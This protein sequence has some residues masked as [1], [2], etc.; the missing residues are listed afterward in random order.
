MASI[1]RI[2]KKNGEVVYRITVC[3]GYDN[4]GK[5]MVKHDTFRVNQ[6]ATPKQ[7]EKEAQKYALDFEDKMKNGY[8]FD[9]EKMTFEEFAEQ[10]VVNIKEELEYGTYECYIFILNNRL[11]PHFKK[12]KLA[13]IKPPIIEDFY[14]KLSHELSDSTLKKHANVLSGIFSTAVRWGIL[15]NNPCRYAKL[16]KRKESGSS[17]KFFTPEQATMFLRSLD[18]VYETEYKGHKRIDD[19]GKPYY[20]TNYVEKHKVNTQ[21]KV[22]YSL[23][24]YCGFRRGET[25]ALKWKDIDFEK[26]E[27][28]ITKS[29]GKTEQ[30][31]DLKKTKT[32]T[33]VRVVPIPD[34]L[35]PLLQS[36]K[37]EYN[38]M[39]MRLGSEWKGNDNIFVRSDGQLMGFGTAY[40]YFKRHLNKY[41]KWVEN[42][43][44]QAKLQGF[45]ILPIIPLHGLRHSCATLL[46]HLDVSIVEISGY[47]GH[48]KSSTT[49]DIYAHTFEEQKREATNKLDMFINENREKHA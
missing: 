38:L 46:N 31:I 23:S 35:L 47:L 4:K 3:M 14:K 15:E 42:N 16:P 9:A 32:N 40:Q 39:R 27:I 8:N 44:E 19:T 25:L 36:Y 49:M 29:V 6:I 43:S 20:V 10:W 41:N 26:K 34:N 24:L 28:S 5:K 48:A 22:F 11:I 18:L 2:E 37:K 12:Y 45:E 13:N 1:K 33:S 30:G 7:Q 21:Y 17:I